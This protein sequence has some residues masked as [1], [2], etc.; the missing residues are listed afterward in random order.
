MGYKKTLPQIKIIKDNLQEEVRVFSVFSRHPYYTQNSMAIFKAFPELGLKIEKTNGKGSED[1]ICKFLVDFY[2]KNKLEVEKIV[3]Q[4][5]IIIKEKGAP[6]L[7]ELAN[8]MDYKWPK[9]V[10]YKA[11]PTILPFSPFGDDNDFNF[12]ILNILQKR[13]CID[14]LLPKFIHEISH[15][16]LFDILNQIKKEEMSV[17]IAED[18]KNY[19][20]EALTAVLLNKNSLRRIFGISQYKGNFEIYGLNIKKKNGEISGFSRFISEQYNQIKNKKETN[21]KIFLIEIIKIL[22]PLSQEFSEK[23]KLWNDYGTK[24]FKNEKLLKEYG[25]PIIIKEAKAKPLWTN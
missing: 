3:D 21:F 9:G 19:F 2:G 12:S 18:V 25:R 22:R 16:V 4:A 11:T 14:S 13:E 5:E 7:K 1:I 15:F 6:V 17:Q 10:I 8:L 23:R 20:K 24:I